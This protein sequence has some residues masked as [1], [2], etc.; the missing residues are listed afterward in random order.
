MC[1]YPFVRD[2]HGATMKQVLLSKEARLAAMP[3]GCGRCLPCKINKAREWTNRIMLESM[4]NSDNMFVTLTYSDSDLPAGASLDKKEVQRWLKI[5]RRNIEPLRFRYYGIGEYGDISFR[6]HYHFCF[7]GIGSLHSRII[8]GTWRRGIVHIGD[9]TKDSARYITGYCVKKLTK[10][11][12]PRLRGRRPEFC[13]SSRRKGGIGL[14]AI[15]QIAANLKKKGSHYNGEIIREVN[16]GGKKLPLGRYLTQKL[17]ERLGV[18]EKLKEEGV[19]FT[20]N[21]VLDHIGKRHYYQGIVDE[22]SQERLVQEK[23][24]KIFSQKRKI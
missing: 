6:P 21:F 8:E 22:K 12:D 3:F 18:D 24:Q 4:V 20:K 9:I 13:I 23:K 11:S 1:K 7:F 14:P 10:P 2:A 17:A 19:E 5:L 16:I 15:D